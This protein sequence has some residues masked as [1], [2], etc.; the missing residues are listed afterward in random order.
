[1]LD[2][3]KHIYLDP[4]IYNTKPILNQFLQEE[5]NKIQRSNYQLVAVRLHY[6]TNFNLLII[7]N[8]IISAMT[9]FSIPTILTDVTTHFLNIAS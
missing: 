3:S 6:E 5:I 7:H 4:L 1:M 2:M 9:I 8:F